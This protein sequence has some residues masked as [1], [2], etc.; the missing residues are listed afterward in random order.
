MKLSGLI[1]LLLLIGITSRVFAQDEMKL[2]MGV[3]LQKNI[4]KKLKVE[5]LPEIRLES[6]TQLEET[7]LETGLSYKLLKFLD[8]AG[9]YRLSFIPEQEGVQHRFA[10]DLKP[11]VALK[12]LKLQ[13]RLR[14]TNYTDFDIET[15]DNSTY[16][17]SRL[18]CKY[19]FNNFPITPFVSAELY[20]RA[21]KED[22]NK[23]RYGTGFELRLNK[24]TEV[25]CY[26][27]LRYKHKNDK[28]KQIIGI[29]FKIKI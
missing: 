18:Q 6:K 29:E 5:L 20:Y 28:T 16:F 27:L 22:F 3:Q 15:E 1:L 10:I 8:V 12:D 9:Q 25:E 24:N 4:T 11:H 17:R 14:Y 21:D 19:D 23:S 7:L 26:Y 2:R 13:Y